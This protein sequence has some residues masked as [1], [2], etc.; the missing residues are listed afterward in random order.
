MSEPARHAAI[1]FEP[2]GYDLRRPTLVG[3]QVASHGFL[4]AATAA[5]QGGALTGYGP[6]ACGPAFGRLLAELAPAVR[7]DWIAQ[8]QL[9]RLAGA[10]VCH[11]P[12]PQLG[13]EA[14]L[15][16]RAG[17]SAYALSGVV[18]T[19]AS[20]LDQLASLLA[21]PLTPWDALICP[22][23]AI[24]RTLTELFGAQAD[25]LRWRFGPHAVVAPLQTPVIP[26]G[27]HTGDFAFTPAERA[28]AR[29]TLGLA[30][31]EVVAL[32][33]G[34]LS[35]INKAHPLPMYLGL[36]AAHER[37]G[38]KVALVE[39]GWSDLPAVTNAMD[40][41]AADFCP[42]VRR[43]VID[44]R[45]PA[46]ARRCWAAADLFISLSDNPQETFGL[47]P[48][49]AM[50]AGL[51]AVVS[52]WNGYRE[53]VRDGVDGFRIPTW[54]PQGGAGD[55]LSRAREAGAL[56]LD[57]SCYAAAVST[58]VEVA[59]LADR[60]TELVANPDL[61]RRLG[62]AGRQRAHA[63]Y[64]WQAIYA[65]HQALWAQMD[66]RRRAASAQELAWLAAAPRVWP[67]GADFFSVFGHYPTATIG[68]GTRLSLSPGVTFERYRAIVGHPLFPLEPAPERVVA[69]LWPLLEAGPVTLGEA[70]GAIGASP[71][72]VILAVGTLAKMGLVTLQADGSGARA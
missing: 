1:Y 17:P 27:V 18:H 54:A 43:Q 30:E 19:T 9:E 64:G 47:T 15:R 11:R 10:G 63:I 51:P 26:L 72:A 8:E 71:A 13:R 2:D 41:G 14:R 52:D 22:S 69:P 38:R 21:E 61:R 35:F 49:E 58:A 66:A 31:D 33:V 39:C 6:A 4:R 56:P 3:R 29:R 62:E 40:R 12:D 68:L 28:E 36:Q 65:Q 16:L 23:Q 37:T 50:A 32:F 45:D 48:I 53:S 55:D 42:D 60:L 5:A 24:A 67:A 34:R 44:G 46:A 7:A 20:V 70:A 25:Y 59:P 57:L